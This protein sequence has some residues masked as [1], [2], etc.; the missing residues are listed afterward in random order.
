MIQLKSLTPPRQRLIR[1]MQQL[2]FGQI[3]NLQLLRG[4]PVL[5]PPLTTVEDVKLDGQKGPRPEHTL[6]DFI[7]KDQHLELF[8]EFDRIGT[9]YLD[10]LTVRHGLPCRLLISRSIA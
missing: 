6:S 7:L 1:M 4:E 10:E 8:K 2:N 5:G 9:G 3:R